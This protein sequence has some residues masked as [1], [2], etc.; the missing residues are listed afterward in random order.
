[1]LFSILSQSIPD[2]CELA[3]A[4]QTCGIEGRGLP[5]FARKFSDDDSPN[6]N[7]SKEISSIWGASNWQ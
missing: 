4:F 6:P 5:I 2:F 3:N 1:L 7:D